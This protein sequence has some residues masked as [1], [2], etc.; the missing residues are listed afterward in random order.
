[1]GIPL[2]IWNRIKAIEIDR[3]RIHLTFGDGEETLRDGLLHGIT[4]KQEMV[5]I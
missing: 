3:E 4:I 1:M 5:D 2:S